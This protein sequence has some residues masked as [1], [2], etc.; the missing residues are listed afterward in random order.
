MHRISR[1]DPHYHAHN[2]DITPGII[3]IL[4][5]E[6]IVSS[7]RRHTIC[8]FN[9]SIA[10][11]Y[12][13]ARVIGLKPEATIDPQFT[14]KNPFQKN[15]PWSEMVDGTVILNENSFLNFFPNKVDMRLMKFGPKIMVIFNEYVSTTIPIKPMYK[16]SNF[17]GART[18]VYIELSSLDG[19]KIAE[20][21]EYP[22]ADRAAAVEKNWSM[23]IAR[24]ETLRISYS[25]SP[26]HVFFKPDATSVEKCSVMEDDTVFQFPEHVH[27]SLGTPA[28]RYDYKNAMLAVGH[29]KINTKDIKEGE[30]SF[31]I[32]NKATHPNASRNYKYFMFFYKFD[33]S[34]GKI[35]G[36]SG[37]F[38]P[39]DGTPHRIFFPTGLDAGP[40]EFSLAYGVDD[41]KSNILTLTRDVIESLFNKE[42]STTIY[43][44]PVHHAPV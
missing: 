9:P 21:I 3:Q 25:L 34:T 39:S 19:N 8:V 16:F 22:C 18:R 28:V 12:T 35:L 44:I 1:F 24:D 37:F 17:P 36:Y 29:A 38:I 41:S 40:Y 11:G 20:P 31:P 42:L 33:S 10:G 13:S 32:E 15:I 6:N 26:H 43:P 4:L 23:W 14:F 27:I 30:Y 7:D 5:E 2:E